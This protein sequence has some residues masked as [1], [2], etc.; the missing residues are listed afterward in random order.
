[1]DAGWPDHPEPMSPDEEALYL[2]E[3]LSDDETRCQACGERVLKVATRVIDGD[4]LCADCASEA[5]ADDT[6]PGVRS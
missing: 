1:M 3:P 6:D 2:G 5:E 4:V